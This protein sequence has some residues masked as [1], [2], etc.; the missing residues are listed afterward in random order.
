MQNSVSI[1]L[2][3][4]KITFMDLKDADF[5][6]VSDDTNKSFAENDYLLQ[7]INISPEELH[8]LID[9]VLKASTK[10]HYG[11]VAYNSKG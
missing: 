10:Y 11:T 3:G 9:P 8:P 4:E 2:E 1:E 5:Q 6:Q 7:Y